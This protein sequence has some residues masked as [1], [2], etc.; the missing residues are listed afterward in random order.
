MLQMMDRRLCRRMLALRFGKLRLE[1]PRAIG[2]IEPNFL[3]Q[4]IELQ[5]RIEMRSIGGTVKV[6]IKTAAV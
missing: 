1:F 6:P 3:G 2:R 4:G 5:Q